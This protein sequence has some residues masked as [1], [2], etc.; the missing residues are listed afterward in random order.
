MHFNL[1]RPLYLRLTRSAMLERKDSE[2]LKL[3]RAKGV[4]GT[5][6]IRKHAFR[7]AMILHFGRDDTPRSG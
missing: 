7:N 2:Y 3:A 1:L 4:S 5:A 6:L